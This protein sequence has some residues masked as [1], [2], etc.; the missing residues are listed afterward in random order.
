MMDPL[1]LHRPQYSTMTIVDGVP[2]IT[3][4]AYMSVAERDARG[5]PAAVVTISQ[6]FSS[7]GSTETLTLC[8]QYEVVRPKPARGTAKAVFQRPV[9]C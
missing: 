3:D 7:N 5:T 1:G 4:Q 8:Y 2:T 9:A 6:H